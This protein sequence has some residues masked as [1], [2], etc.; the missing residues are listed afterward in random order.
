[1]RKKLNSLV[2]NTVMFLILGLVLYILFNNIGLV[3]NL[4]FGAGAYYYADIPDFEKYTDTVVVDTVIPT[5]IYGVLFIAWGIF[6]CFVWRWM[7][8]RIN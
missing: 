6:I 4:D 5:W 3:D 1:M 8:R 7:E 2:I